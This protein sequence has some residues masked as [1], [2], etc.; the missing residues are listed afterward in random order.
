MLQSA[1]VLKSARPDC[2]T[3]SW[4]WMRGQAAIIDLTCP[5]L[6]GALAA[7]GVDTVAEYSRAP[8]ERSQGRGQPVQVCTLDAREELGSYAVHQPGDRGVVC[9]RRRPLVQQFSQRMSGFLAP[10]NAGTADC[11][12]NE[13]ELF[14][15]GQQGVTPTTMLNRQRPAAQNPIASSRNPVTV[16]ADRT[17]GVRKRVTQERKQHGLRCPQLVGALGIPNQPLGEFQR[18]F[19]FSWRSRHFSVCSLR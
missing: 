5:K 13:I 6:W 17:R 15:L 7:A 3:R 16:L 12:Q 1:V 18:A 11:L 4:A 2:S 9:P 14:F 10:R 8:P 19:G